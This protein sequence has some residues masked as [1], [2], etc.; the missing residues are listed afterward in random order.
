V[1]AFTLQ[2]TGLKRSFHGDDLT[3][4]QLV[5]QSLAGKR[6][7]KTGAAFYANTVGN[8][9]IID[10]RPGRELVASVKVTNNSSY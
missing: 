7:A 1:N 6:T 10:A 9:M 4:R 5:S 8:S 2:D 3:I